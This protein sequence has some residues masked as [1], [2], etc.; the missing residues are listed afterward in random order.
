MS[1]ELILHMVIKKSSFVAL[2]KLNYLVMLQLL[3][4]RYVEKISEVKLL[5]KRLK[6]DLRFKRGFGF[7]VTQKVHKAQNKKRHSSS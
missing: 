6:N 2:V 7:G 4:I 5:V 3:I 1:I